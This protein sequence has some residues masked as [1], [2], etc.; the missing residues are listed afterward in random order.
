[1]EVTLEGTGAINM[2]VSALEPAQRDE[3]I[4]SITLDLYH[5]KSSLITWST[6]Y[7]L[8]HVTGSGE[9]TSK[10]I[11]SNIKNVNLIKMGF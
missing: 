6:Q 1:M 7:F 10:L 3:K 5:N 11:T 2:D 4:C 9:L 8:V